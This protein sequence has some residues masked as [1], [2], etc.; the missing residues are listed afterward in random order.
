MGQELIEHY[1]LLY[2]DY[3]VLMALVLILQYL[4]CT[5]QE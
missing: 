2:Q 5:Y 1:I 3:E 4:P